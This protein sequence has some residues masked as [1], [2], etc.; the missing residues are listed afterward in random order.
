MDVASIVAQMKSLAVPLVLF[1]ALLVFVMVQGR[2][3]LTSLILGL[4]LALLL[5]L[6]FPYYDFLFEHISGDF[7]SDTFIRISLFAIFTA[8]GAILFDRLLFYRIDEGMFEAL[9]K[10]MLLALLGTILILAFSYHVLPFA[11]L[12]APDTVIQ[13]FFAPHELFFWWLVLPL[14]VLFL[15]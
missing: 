4:Y 3:A 9:P 5:S 7:I 8:V 6:V 12:V 1:S 11:S 15:L 13:T 14:L 10:K 2:R